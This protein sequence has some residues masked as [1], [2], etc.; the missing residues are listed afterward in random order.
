MG[1]LL[2]DG[3]RYLLLSGPKNLMSFTIGL[4]I[5]YITYVISDNYARIK[6]DSL[7]CLLLEKKIGL[8]SFIILMSVLNENQKRY[9]HNIF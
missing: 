6:I 7:D 9:Y 8:H 5:I 3:T 1:L 2:H 4:D